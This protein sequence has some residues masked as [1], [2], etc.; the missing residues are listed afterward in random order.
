MKKFTEI[1]KSNLLKNTLNNIIEFVKDIPVVSKW[2]I[3][4]VD[5]VLCIVS[6]FIT[7]AVT[8]NINPQDFFQHFAIKMLVVLAVT[9]TFSFIFKVHNGILRYSTYRDIFFLGISL[10]LANSILTIINL[11]YEHY[12]GDVSLPP[13]SFFINFVF[14]FNAM[15]F[16]RMIVRLI[17]D[18]TKNS[19]SKKNKNAVLIYGV[20]PTSIGIAKMIEADEYSPYY[21]SGFISSNED[22]T[23]SKILR[24]PVIF[25]EH[26]YKNP[27]KINNIKSIIINPQEIDMAEKR[28]LSEICFEEHIELLTVPSVDAWNI[29]D[30]KKLNIED[31][32]GRDTIKIN[33]QLISENLNEKVVLV[34]GAAGSIGSEIARQLCSFDIKMLICCDVAE[35]PLHNLT[36]ELKEKFPKVNFVSQI[37]DV[38]NW[39]AMKEVFEKYHPQ[40]IYHAAAYKHVPMMENHPKEAVRTNVKGT[41]IVADLAFEYN[42]ECFVMIS[43]D[44]AV[45]PSN[46]M[47]ASKRIAE[48][49]IRILSQR[50]AKKQG[51]TRYIITRF[52]NVLGSNGSVV[53]LFTEQ[54]K[55]GGPLTVTHP[56]IIRY[57]MTI[58]EACSLVLDAGHLG[59][60]GEIFLFDMGEPVKIKDMAEDMIR[61]M[62]YEPY[63][64]INIIFSGLR[65]GE[66]LY[67]ELLYNRDDA[68][69]TENKKIIIDKVKIHDE[70]I[71]LPK[72]DS[73]FNIA[74]IGNNLDVVKIMKSIVPEFK[75]QCSEFETLDKK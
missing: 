46:V 45:N 15:F 56:E 7:Y 75:S 29:R 57:F 33:T 74:E 71:V 72:I 9:I 42:A 21:V 36:L 41:K 47:G 59:K 40:Y 24:Q 17:F 19:Y 1:F 22:F 28:V 26:F 35:T 38:R 34:T 31:L 65:P 68:K 11:I 5:I 63:K 61:L 64:D 6:F 60:G 23:R 73:L 20:S 18:L 3:L 27:K 50:V 13:L 16:F 44:K 70:T 39:T 67:E 4:S 53:P 2:L 49:Y 66:K 10:F 69:Y 51:T 43:T 55:N 30:I 52:G 14:T 25:K 62:G 58:P 54:I 32:L 37:A 48:I 8:I 12:S